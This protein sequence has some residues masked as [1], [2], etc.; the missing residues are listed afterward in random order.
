MRPAIISLALIAAFAAKAHALQPGDLSPALTAQESKYYQGIQSDPTASQNFLIT[1]DY[2]R[3]A[4]FVT[5][6]P[7]DI[8]AAANLPDKPLGFSA[9]YLLPGEATMINDALSLSIIAG[10]KTSASPW[11]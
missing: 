7:K 2:A 4:K 10:M 6:H 3:K 5:D 8:N 9:R 1:R 11:A